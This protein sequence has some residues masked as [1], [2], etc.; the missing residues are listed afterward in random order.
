MLPLILSIAFMV[1]GCVFVFFYLRE[2][3]QRY[4]VKAVLL[5]TICSLF[6]IAVGAISLFNKAEH[7]LPKYV[8]LGLVVGMLGDIFLDL[9]YVHKEYD[10]EYSYAGFIAFGVGHILFMTGLFREY[11]TDQSVLYI[12]IPLVV[13]ILFGVLT[14]LLEK[15]MKLQYGDMKVISMIYGMILFSCVAVTVSISIMTGF[16]SVTTILF[17]VGGV[18]FAVSDLILSGTYFG[19]GKERPVDLISNIALYYIAQFSIA[20][21]MYFL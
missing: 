9:K 14:V 19:K 6:F 8:I 11:Y 10:K 15:P 20:F 16:K 13:G 3:V 21:S 12:I 5:K 4:S 7:V 1:C 2:K 17:G 18:L